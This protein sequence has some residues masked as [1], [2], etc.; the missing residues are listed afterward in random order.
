MLVVAL[1]KEITVAEGR[2]LVLQAPQQETTDA[3]N[4]DQFLDVFVDLPTA[5]IEDDVADIAQ[6]ANSSKSL[7]E[8][9]TRVVRLAIERLQASA[10][11]RSSLQREMSL[12]KDK[13]PQVNRLLGILSG[14]LRFVERLAHTNDPDIDGDVRSA[15]LE[16]A[17]RIHCFLADNAAGLIENVSIFDL[18]GLNVDPLLLKNGLVALFN[19]YDKV[20]EDNAGEWMVLLRQAMAAALLIKRYCNEVQTQCQ[21]YAA[22]VT[23][24]R[25]DVDNF[26]R[27]IDQRVE[28]ARVDAEAESLASKQKLAVAVDKM[29]NVEK[30]LKSNILNPNIS[31]QVSRCLDAIDEDTVFTISDQEV[32]GA[33][34]CELEDL[35]KAHDQTVEELKETRRELA[36]FQNATSKE[37][38]E[39]GES[40]AIIEQDATALIQTQ[41]GEIERLSAIVESQNTELKQTRETIVELQGAIEQ[42]TIAKEAEVKDLKTKASRK[43]EKTVRLIVAEQN[44]RIDK[45]N[46]KI[47]SAKSEI[48]KKEEAL[49]LQQEKIQSQE[50]TQQD[51]GEQQTQIEDE[52][53]KSAAQ[54]EI[55]QQSLRAQSGRVA[56]LELDL[57]LAQNRLKTSEEKL[58]RERAHFDNQQ[59]LRQFTA[60]AESQSRADQIAHEFS[61][62]QRLFFVEICNLFKDFVDFSIP[63]TQPNVLHMLSEVSTKVKLMS[64]ENDLGSDFE[65]QI[66]EIRVIVSAPKGTRT[67]AVIADLVE[68][69]S[70]MKQKVER[71]EQLER[72]RVPASEIRNEWTE[73]GRRV[74]SSIKSGEVPP[75]TSNELR[76]KLEDALF[77]AASHRSIPEKL[78]QLRRQKALLIRGDV[79]FD[80]ALPTTAFLPIICS[81]M[82]YRRILRLSHQIPTQNSFLPTRINLPRDKSRD[83]Q[84]HASGRTSIASIFRASIYE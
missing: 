12:F 70:S 79:V 62:K 41:A 43:L 76:V 11:H 33:L 66:K 29:K 4:S 19:T 26:R 38:E 82:F 17:A 64:R 30:I 34:R 8:R 56:E 46:A 83:L 24:L 59:A 32:V 20:A 77:A 15:M 14:Q 49:A 31:A 78:A 73:W 52:L 16:N 7:K 67:P 36:A 51:L 10:R 57:K 45:L 9:L 53:R 3:L 60:D 54:L 1:K 55:A 74:Y 35:Q 71:Y 65:R 40:S 58:E 18:L 75:R 13:T 80:R 47:K 21:H 22:E 81:M 63:M 25:K 39:I 68:T 84:K 28:S 69:A 42:L 2:T 50:A 48:Q 72:E 61:E 6:A 44:S 27:E 37:I 23:I 5:D